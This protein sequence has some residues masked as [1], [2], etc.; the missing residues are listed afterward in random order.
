MS[1]FDPRPKDR[2]EDFFDRERE[3]DEFRRSISS[4][5]LT[6]VLGLRRYG[7]T[8]LILTGLNEFKV[9]YVYL[10]CKA[11]PLGMIS[12]GDFMQLFVEALNTFT[13]R[14]SGLR[15]RILRL[16]D[17][18]E[19]ISVSGFTVTINLRRFKPQNLFE[20]LGRLNDIGEEVVLV[21]DEAQE[22]RRLARYR[23]DYILAY[24]YD[25]LRNI[26]LVVSG[27]QVGLL[28]RLLRIGDPEAPLYGRAYSEVRLGKLSI[29]KS[30]E[31]L[32]L[33]YQQHGIKPPRETIEY[34]ISLVDG[35]IG[36]LAY[37]GFK[38]IQKKRID[39]RVVDEV[40]REAY[41][42]VLQELKH[43]LQL[44]PLAKERYQ[45]ILKIVALLGNATWTNIYNYIQAQLGKVPKPTFNSL[46]KNL[47]DAGFIEKKE[48]KYTITD[49]IL[50]K[51]L[52]EAPIR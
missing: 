39:N 42:L 10:D 51:A 26:R 48:D 27:S 15:S 35:V 47:V 9:R 4:S 38:T 45:A 28:Y 20:L 23:A 43:F 31:F 18:I 49:P 24:I 50:R 14:Y 13:R 12:I 40:V 29:E 46:L 16:L 34:I 44:R 1:L 7:K 8:S 22:L 6:L 19:G 11:L 21:I 33:G 41:K 37:I 17:S 3:L 2:L 25:N 32:E 52:L 30:R 36:W 5:P